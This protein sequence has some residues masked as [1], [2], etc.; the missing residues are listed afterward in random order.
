MILAVALCLGTASAQIPTAEDA[1][2]AEVISTEN[3][4]DSLKP[5]AVWQPATVGQKLAWHDRLRTGEDSRAAVRLGD[6]SILRLDELTE[7]EVLPPQIA[8]AKPTV[9]LKQ[10]T[11]YFFSREKSREINVQTPAVNGGIRGTEFVVTVAANGSTRFTMI[12]GEVE[13]SNS[14]GSLVVQSGERADIALNQ[15]PAKSAVSNPIDSAEWCFYYPGVLDPKEATDSLPD[16]DAIKASLSAY[17]E[18]DLLAALE[19]YPRDRL[20]ASSEEKIYRAG[21]F[22]ASGQV[23]KA[24]GLLKELDPNVPNREAISTLIAAIT[25]KEKEKN[26]APPQTAS[27]WMAQ[28]YY[29]QSIGHLLSARQ[30]AERATT[31]DPDFGFSWTRLAEVALSQGQKSQ[32]KEAL[33]K[34]LSLAPNNPAA[35]ALRG[36]IL[37]AEGKLNEAIGS[38]EK[39]LTFDSA[40]GDAW[41]GRGLCL[42]RQG[43]LKAGRRDLFTAAAL[44]PNR[45]I[46]RKYLEEASDRAGPRSTTH[47][48]RDARSETGESSRPPKPARV[49]PPDNAVTPEPVYPGRLPGSGISIYP[50]DYPV[51]SPRPRPSATPGRSRPEKTPPPGRNPE[52]TPRRPIPTPRLTLSDRPLPG[53]QIGQPQPAPPARG[54][55]APGTPVSQDQSK[56]RKKRPTASQSPTPN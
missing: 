26:A 21:L 54:A 37:R 18:G 40:L 56:G 52:R 39:A 25:L 33:E 13:L 51:R 38:F 16:R 48:P 28:S 6:L 34:G 27:E 24:E 49:A 1:N 23:A 31:L 4:V 3:S 44:E 50:P 5:P 53:Q 11:V 35:H 10:G 22:L 2:Q 19:Q 46:F 29:L 7:A 42:I 15:E 30:A 43:K 20:P 45:A 17:G 8:T 14:S 12:D 9:D 55:V 32:A 36:S 47:K 41:A